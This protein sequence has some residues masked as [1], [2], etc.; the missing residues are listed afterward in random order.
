MLFCFFKNASCKKVNIFQST[1]L[2]RL[3]TKSLVYNFHN[4]SK[5]DII[6]VLFQKI[7]WDY[8]VGY[9]EHKKWKAVTYI[10][11]CYQYETCNYCCT[12]YDS[13]DVSKWHYL[14]SERNWYHY[15]L[16]KYQT[17]A[18]EIKVNL[19]NK[20]YCMS[21]TY[22]FVDGASCFRSYIFSTN[23]YTRDVDLD[24][25]LIFG[26]YARKC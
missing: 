25:H 7:L 12:Y 10:E 11:F 23:K 8:S 2:L 22:N 26:I 4:E 6:N 20:I 5:P 19:T 21:I 18:M 24:M 16:V 13:A 14:V 15:Y 17:C 1:T 9:R 3:Q